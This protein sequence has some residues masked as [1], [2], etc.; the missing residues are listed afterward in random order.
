M[1][2]SYEDWKLLMEMSR[3]RNLDHILE[4]LYVDETF[5]REYKGIWISS[6]GW[7]D[8]EII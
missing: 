1:M 3:L 2:D 7:N 5:E 8:N 6:K 4:E